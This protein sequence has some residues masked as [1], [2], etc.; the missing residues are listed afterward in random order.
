MDRLKQFITDHHTA[1]DTGDLPTGHRLRFEEKL[2]A[3]RIVFRPRYFYFL[4]VAAAVLFACF[5]LPYTF[6]NRTQVI[7]PINCQTAEDMQQLSMYY[8]W[9]LYDIS[10]QLKL[11]L[12]GQNSSGG[13]YLLQESSRILTSGKYFEDTVIPSL[14]CTQQSLFAITQFY[15]ANLE[16]LN[17]MLRQAD[18]INMN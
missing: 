13:Q 5:I 11:K 16:S 10:N 1:F 7:Y 4:G 14:P 15:N 12:S 9:Q 18:I 2:P 8:N 6:D 17:F 3:K